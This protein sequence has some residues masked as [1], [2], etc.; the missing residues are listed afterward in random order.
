MH[1][2][3][4]FSPMRSEQGSIMILSLALL[5]MIS[6]V[7]VIHMSNSKRMF[8]QS[9][10]QKDTVQREQLLNATLSLLNEQQICASV[11]P[12]QYGTVPGKYIFNPDLIQGQYERA[13]QRVNSVQSA[14]R[15]TELKEINLLDVRESPPDDEGNQFKEYKVS[16]MIGPKPKK[17]TA[18]RPDD[19]FT[20]TYGLRDQNGVAVNKEENITLRISKNGRCFAHRNLAADG[21]QESP[22]AKTCQ[23]LG[24]PNA[25]QNGQC[26]VLSKRVDPATQIL[27]NQRVTLA[28]SSFP[29]ALCEMELT[30]LRKIGPHIIDSSG[31]QLKYGWTSLCRKPKWSGCRYRNKPESN[32]YYKPGQAVSDRWEGKAKD[33][34]EAAKNFAKPTIQRRTARAVNRIYEDRMNVPGYDKNIDPGVLGLANA[35]GGGVAVGIMSGN[36]EDVAVAVALNLMFGPIV[37]GI[38]MAFGPKCDKGKIE[39]IQRCTEGGVETDRLRLFTQK[40][41][42]FFSCKWKENSPFV[43]PTEEQIRLDLLN[44]GQ[45]PI[46]TVRAP[47]SEP[48]LTADELKEFAEELETVKSVEGLYQLVQSF[49][50][51]NT[52]EIRLDPEVMS[53]IQKREDALLSDMKGQVQT[54]VSNKDRPGLEALET[55]VQTI[56]NDSTIP[57]Y[58]HTPNFQ[59]QINTIDQDVRKGLSAI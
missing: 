39:A 15:E 6:V 37:G 40:R 23:A 5:A 21:P 17:N 28:S 46:T 44:K 35:L 4:L 11:F 13:K 14:F 59:G 47:A 26:N 3:K 10:Y 16:F 9:K 48:Q 7:A 54:A 2:K 12:A 50:N 49:A 31:N 34:G 32:V 56:R 55:Q 18:G 25:Y 52:G 36:W 27:T 30:A 38:I 42:R 43:V 53:L 1:P 41:K 29:N 57:G 51:P 20:K 22:L 58:R 33:M 45:F 24:G 8:D 19:S